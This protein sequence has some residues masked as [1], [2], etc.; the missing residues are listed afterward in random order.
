MVTQRPHFTQV[1]VQVGRV[2]A[3]KLDN[4]LVQVN[5]TVRARV[6]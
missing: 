2:A 4:A 3:P 6:V 1:H 5:P